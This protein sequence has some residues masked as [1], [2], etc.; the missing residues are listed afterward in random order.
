MGR[1]DARLIAAL[2][3]GLAAVPTAGSA[4]AAVWHWAC[5][6]ELGDQR[7]LFDRE[8]LYIASGKDAAGKP[9]KVTADS[10]QEAI[11]LVKKDGGFTEFAPDDANGGL[12]SPIT[13]SQTD[14]EKQEQKVVFTERS[15]KRISHRH[16]IVACRDEDTDLYRKV[17]RYQRDGEPARNI[18]M[19][20]MEYQLS[21]KGGRKGCD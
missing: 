13:F 18:T 16:R 3:T 20:C 2:L 6:G 5:Q 17:Y 1:S 11:V 4:S 8:G 19:H 10:I 7:I 9:V 21:T 14:G 12:E 15:S